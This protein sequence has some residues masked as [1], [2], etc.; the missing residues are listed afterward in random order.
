MAANSCV[1]KFW[2][3][4]SLVLLWSQAVYS[5]DSPELLIGSSLENLL[6]AQDPLVSSAP[7]QQIELECGSK[8]D[9]SV[10]FGGATVEYKFSE[11]FEG[12]RDLT[13]C[14]N[15]GLSDCTSTLLNHIDMRTP[16]ASCPGCGSCSQCDSL[17]NG[18]KP[19]KTIDM[20]NDNVGHECTA[21]GSEPIKSCRIECWLE[22]PIKVTL[23]CTKCTHP[24]PPPASTGSIHVL[25]EH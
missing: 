25:S 16:A 18:C 19:R 21:F 8:R 3:L 2:L 10:S 14:C 17:L 24:P 1:S 5:E 11:G 4:G 12:V 13:N 6:T 7:P 15:M 22:Q 9:R 23:E 20:P